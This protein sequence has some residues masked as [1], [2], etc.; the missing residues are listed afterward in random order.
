MPSRGRRRTERVRGIGGWLDRQARAS[1]EALARCVSPT[2]R[3]RRRP[4]FGCTVRAVPGAVVA[5]PRGAALAGE[6]DYFFHWFRDAAMVLE[7][8]LVCIRHRRDALAWRRRIDEVVRFHLALTRIDGRSFVAR[9]RAVRAAA[10]ARMRRYVRP[11][12]ELAACR[13]AAMLGEAR[14]NADGTPDVLRWSRPQHDGPALLALMLLRAGALLPAGDAAA[15]RRDALIALL[16]DYTLAHADAPGHDLW[17]EAIGR[18]YFTRLA[19]YA[20]L[21]DGAR[22][23]RGRGEHGGARRCA[24]AAA[25]LSRALASMW[26]PRARLYRSRSPERRGRAVPDAAVLLGALRAGVALRRHGVRDPRVV[27]TVEGLIARAARD[28]PINRGAGEGMVAGR[29]PGDVYCGGNP[30]FLVGFAIAELCYRRAAAAP[31]AAA[32]ALVAR[33]DAMLGAARRWLPADGTIP[34]QLDRCSGAPVSARDLAWSHAALL[35]AWEARRE[36]LRDRW[37]RAVARAQP[38]S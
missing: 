10:T 31:A 13:G 23:L 26:S 32:A 14:C 17:E 34:E 11:D 35:T 24:A 6:P 22:W 1:A 2:G 12:A 38:D 28:F 7:A 19:Q 37:R 18:H 21:R 8:A 3:R 9:Q 20:A 27:A 30:W 5:S 36:A 33:G 16:L 29:Y 25:G 15:R 4:A